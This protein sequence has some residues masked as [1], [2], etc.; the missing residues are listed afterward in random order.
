MDLFTDQVFFIVYL[1]YLQLEAN[2]YTRAVLRV[3]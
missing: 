2:L 3:R 1:V